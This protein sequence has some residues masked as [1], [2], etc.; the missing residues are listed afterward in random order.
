MTPVP[1]EPSIADLGTAFAEIAASVWNIGA[2][3]VHD[4]MSITSLQITLGSLVHGQHVES[5]DLIEILTVAE[6][7]EKAAQ[8]LADAIRNSLTFDGRENLSEH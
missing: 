4:V 5:S 6:N 7:V 8:Y 1:W 2:G 3:V